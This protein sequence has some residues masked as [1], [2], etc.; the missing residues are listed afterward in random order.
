MRK[1]EIMIESRGMEKGRERGRQQW[2]IHTTTT[3]Q[4]AKENRVATTA[5]PRQAKLRHH[6]RKLTATISLLVP[7]L[8]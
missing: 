4:S 7:F 5:K 8:L 6:R 2:T 3:S 1:S